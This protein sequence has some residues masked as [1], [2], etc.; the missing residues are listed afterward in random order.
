LIYINDIEISIITHILCFGQAN[1]IYRRS[2]IAG[3]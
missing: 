1:E 2:F 3:S